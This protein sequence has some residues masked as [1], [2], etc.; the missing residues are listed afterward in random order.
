MKYFGLVLLCGMAC[1][2]TIVTPAWRTVNGVEGFYLCYFMNRSV[3]I[4]LC[5]EYAPVL[6]AELSD[7]IPYIC[8]ELP[9]LSTD[10]WE[11]IECNRGLC[12][13]MPEVYYPPRIKVPEPKELHVRRDQ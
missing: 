2:Q 10:Y 3:P 9:S 11:H 5:E 6:Q 7:Q 13:I 8:C 12:T 1:A 4:S